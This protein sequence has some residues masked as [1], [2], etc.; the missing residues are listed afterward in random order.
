MQKER[1]YHLIFVCEL[2]QMAT[3]RVCQKDIISYRVTCLSLAT[4]QTFLIVIANQSQ[5]KILLMVR[6][7]PH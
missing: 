4:Q 6:P 3:T 5:R 7:R 2:K 1:E